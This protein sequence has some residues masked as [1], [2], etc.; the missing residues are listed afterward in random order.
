MQQNQTLKRVTFFCVAL[1]ALVCIWIVHQADTMAIASEEKKV[2]ALE[3]EGD[4]LIDAEKVINALENHNPVPEI[5]GGLETSKPLFDEKYNWSEQ[6]RVAKLIR[7]LKCHAEEAWPYLLKHFDDKRYCV[8]VSELEG[9]CCRN[10]TIG[11]VCQDMVLHYLT[12]A[13]DRHEPPSESCKRP[14][15]HVLCG[16]VGW[17][18]SAEIV[19][20]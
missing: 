6:E 13:C 8:T 15:E 17:D 19:S 4:N 18:S 7:F 20:A 9:D 10:F 5:I 16:R 12:A 2:I 11:K 3:G 14:A 1:Q